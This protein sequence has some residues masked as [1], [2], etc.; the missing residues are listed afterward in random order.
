MHTCLRTEELGIGET[1]SGI[2]QGQW[3]LNGPRTSGRDC[4][5]ISE[6]QHSE[7]VRDEDVAAPMR[8]GVHLLTDVYRPAT[9]GSLCSANTA[10]L[11]R[12]KDRRAID[13]R[14]T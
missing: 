2:E 10:W 7:T 5:N 3:Q 1:V 13:Y 14:S 6:P 11:G 9:P 8:D 4:R 12:G